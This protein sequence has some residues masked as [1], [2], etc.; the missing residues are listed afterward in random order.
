M[1][2]TLMLRA[3]LVA[4]AVVTSG[5]VDA[6]DRAPVAREA[7]VTDLA[8]PASALDVRPAGSRL[9]YVSGCGRV[10]VYRVICKLTVGSC[11]A[12]KQ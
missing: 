3:A 12:L 11:Y 5:C 1:S 4:I 7:A 8:C 9:F 6:K 10:A 2:A